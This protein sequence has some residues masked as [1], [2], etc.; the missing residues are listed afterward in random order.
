MIRVVA[1]NIRAGGGKRIGRIAAQIDKWEA[2][3]VGLCEFRATPPSRWLQEA[4]AQRGLF[5]QITT[6]DPEQPSA[7]R[8]LV[9][10]RW[11]IGRIPLSASPRPTQLWLP[12]LV[13]APQPFVLGALYIP[14]AAFSGRQKYA[15]H[16]AILRIAR[17]WDY[18][19]ALIT[20]DTNTGRIGIDE[21]SHAF[22]KESDDWMVG[23]ER[24]GWRDAF[25]TLHGDQR[26]YTWYSPNAGNGFR[27]DQAFV[28]AELIPRLIAARYEWAAT[29]DGRRDAVSDH[30]ALLIDLTD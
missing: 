3:V 9:A 17:R 18:G 28:N 6:A 21:Q 15:F 10:S 26:T 11:P 24:A 22:S 29:L 5:Y 30:A 13:Q 8:L 7:N 14:M 4:L 2:D 12:A 16:R 20:G 23:M 19:P 25:R 1:W 27:L